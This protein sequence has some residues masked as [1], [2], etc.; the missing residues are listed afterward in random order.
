MGQGQKDHVVPRKVLDRGVHQYAVGERM[1]VRGN[2]AKALPG[3]GMRGDRANFYLWVGRED[4]QDL[5]AGIT[6]G[7]GNSY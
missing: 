4:A 2:A 7:S 5:A 6:A 1:Q 3:L